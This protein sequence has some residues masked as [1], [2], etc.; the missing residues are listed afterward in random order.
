[1]IDVH[2]VVAEVEMHLWGVAGMVTHMR[3]RGYIG[4]QM[5]V[6]T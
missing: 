6:Y 5:H 1:M 2:G 4:E 3:R